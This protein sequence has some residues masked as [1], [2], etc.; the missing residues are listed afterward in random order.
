MGMTMSRIIRI[1]ESVP[2]S[3]HIVCTKLENLIKSIYALHYD[4]EFIS[5][6]SVFMNKLPRMYQM[7]IYCYF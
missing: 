1:G 7:I 4:S 5:T 3:V 6:R 2:A